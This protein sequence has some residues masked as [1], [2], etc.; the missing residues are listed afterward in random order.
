MTLSLCHIKAG[1]GRACTVPACAVRPRGEHGIRAAAAILHCRHR[2]SA[3]LLAGAA[4]L[5]RRCVHALVLQLLLERAA[6]TFAATVCG[7]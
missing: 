2:R 5:I 6:E 1:Q 7:R 3:R 4:I